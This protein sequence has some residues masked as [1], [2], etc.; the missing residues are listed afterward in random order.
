MAAVPFPRGDQAGVL[1][2]IRDIREQQAA[3]R[4]LRESEAKYRLLA[5][6]AH[7]VIYTLDRDLR[8]T[9]VSP[10]VERLRGISVAEAM[11]E[12]VQ[13]TMTPA[14]YETVQAALTKNTQ[15]GLLDGT[16]VERVE[17]ELRCRDGKTVWVETVVRPMLGADGMF[18][19]FIGSCRDISER[20]AAEEERNRSERFLGR[21]LSTIPDP[22]FVKNEE[23]RFVLV[24]DALC[25]LIGRSSQEFLGRLDVDFVSVEE[26]KVFLAGDDRVLATGE[27]NLSEERI[28]DGQGQSRAIVTKKG[29]LVDGRGNRFI[30]GVIRD[31]TEEKVK[32]SRLRDSLLEKEVLLKE[33][34]HRVKNNLQ[35]ISSLLFLQKEGIA[36]PA[37]QDLFEESRHRIASM[38]FPSKCTGLGGIQSHILQY[39]NRLR[40]GIP[41][42]WEVV[43]RMLRGN[44]DPLPCIA[45]SFQFGRTPSRKLHDT[46][47]SALKCV[48]F[49]RRFAVDGQARRYSRQDGQVVGGFGGHQDKFTWDGRL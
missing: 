32:E 20:R 48:Q 9:Y 33:V 36:D 42:L 25:A 44:N 45:S 46:K 15:A 8:M 18:L 6:N 23:H 47:K 11:T 29:L 22:V 27:E 3:V 49:R 43:A 19:G 26:A 24:N 7:D 30:V 41:F 37:I 1:A 17:L 34:H 38:W 14:S 5:D 16:A 4:A 31:V 40:G 13:D 10:S 35:I 21:I 39:V 12:S 2:F 28:T